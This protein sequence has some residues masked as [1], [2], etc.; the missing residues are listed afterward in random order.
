MCQVNGEPGRDPD[1]GQSLTLSG[2]RKE[3][4]EL[5]RLEMM[6]EKSGSRPLRASRLSESRWTGTLP[7]VTLIS[8]PMSAAGRNSRNR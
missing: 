2:T 7:S 4:R 6:L 3:A 8:W 5:C 1:S